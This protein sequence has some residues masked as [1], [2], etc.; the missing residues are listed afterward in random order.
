LVKKTVLFGQKKSKTAVSLPPLGS[1]NK[2]V[3]IAV[4]SFARLK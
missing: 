2:T 4:S 1:E 3:E